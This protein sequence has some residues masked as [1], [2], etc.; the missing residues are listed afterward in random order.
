[1][2][3]TFC[4]L[5]LNLPNCA[6]RS[7]RAPNFSLGA[8]LLL[9]CR[10]RVFDVGGPYDEACSASCFY[11]ANRHSHPSSLPF[12]IASH[13][14]RSRPAQ[15]GSLPLAVVIGFLA[16]GVVGV[17]GVARS[18]DRLL[19][20]RRSEAAREWP[21]RTGRGVRAQRPK[22][23]LMYCLPTLPC[24]ARLRSAGAWVMCVGRRSAHPEFLHARVAHHKRQRGS[25]I[26][27]ARP[28]HHPL[29]TSDP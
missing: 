13:F 8:I 28:A 4:F 29:R 2:Q 11:T 24:W 1:M 6:A 12:S 23:A 9:H 18:M 15:S 16:G 25:L 22:R 14:L 5:D 21:P 19:V 10:Q 26:A 20:G 3:D 7:L 27:A 17:G